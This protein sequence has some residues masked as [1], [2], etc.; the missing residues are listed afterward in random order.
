MGCVRG[1]ALVTQRCDLRDYVL[2]PRDILVVT[3]RGDIPVEA[4]FGASISVTLSLKG[5]PY[6][7]PF[8]FPSKPI[9]VA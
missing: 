1:E 8:P 9:G 3:R 5:A 2:E 4:L 6:K 7:G